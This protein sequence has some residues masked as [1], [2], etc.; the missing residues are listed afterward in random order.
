MRNQPSPGR[1]SAA[2]FEGLV[3]VIT[4]AARGIGADAA[5][6]FV[7]RGA[8]VAL[9]DRDPAVAQTAGALGE[10]AIGL[11]VDVTDLAS[12]NTAVAE[13]VERFG[14]IDAVV[15]NAGVSGPCATVARVDP[16][17]FERV[18]EINLLGVWRTVRATLPHVVER[19]GYVL[20]VASIAAAIPMPTMAAYAAS[21][22]GVD[23]FAHA[24]RLELAST[25]TDVGVAYFG[26]ID[27]DMVHGMQEQP[28]VAD[29]LTR[30]PG[31]LGRPVPVSEA[32]RVIMR[33]VER[34]SSRVCAPA[35][36]P[37]LMATHGV[38]DRFD[39]LLLRSATLTR[40]IELAGAGAAN[41][42]RLQR[43]ERT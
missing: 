24:L 5:G 18:I 16:A 6:Q 20:V 31:R 36:V 10:R 22:A 19:T 13:V 28:G 29:L 37:A 17:A 26:A 15:A 9:L 41:K 35:Y 2:Y 21:K 23:A 40:A 43:L 32:G 14:G 25:G 7:K 8:R 33:G 12:M 34:R 27:T 1:S 42:T 4:G 38:F 11:V 3:V 39:S 30:L